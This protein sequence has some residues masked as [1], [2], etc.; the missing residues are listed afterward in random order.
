VL[1][2][3]RVTLAGNDACFEAET[4]VASISPDSALYWPNADEQDLFV[5]NFY[6]TLC[7]VQTN[8][9]W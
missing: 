1:A 2:R 3:T 9:S 7:H 4:C 6:W 8:R 5:N